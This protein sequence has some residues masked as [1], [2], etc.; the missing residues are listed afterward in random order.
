M[1]ITDEIKAAGVD[2]TNREAS[3]NYIARLPIPR[4]RREGLWRL[5]A[6]TVGTVPTLLELERVRKEPS[7]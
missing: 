3:L 7:P 1:P 6:T 5:Y 4:D 2:P